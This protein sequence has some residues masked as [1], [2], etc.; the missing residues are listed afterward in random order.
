VATDSADVDADLGVFIIQGIP[1]V[2]FFDEVMDA[3]T[4]VICFD[5][6]RIPES[7]QGRVHATMLFAAHPVGVREN[8]GFGLHPETGNAM[9]FTRYPAIA[10]LTV[11]ALSEAL[12]KGAEQ[13]RYWR[14]TVFPP[15]Q[16]EER[17]PAES[18]V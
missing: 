14:D 17:E 18:F 3:D 13:V 9:M 4:L 15:Q 6:G 11:A 1:A 12:L 10:D 8:L 2:A 7:E 5:M 16:P